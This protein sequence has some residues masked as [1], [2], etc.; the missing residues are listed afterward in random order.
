VKETVGINF[1]LNNMRL[2][3]KDKNVK[4]PSKFDIDAL[5]NSTATEGQVSRANH[6]EH[7]YLPKSNNKLNTI[8]HSI[9]HVDYN[10]D[11]TTSINNSFSTNLHAKSPSNKIFKEI[12]N[13]SNSLRGNQS[14]EKSTYTSKFDESGGKSSIKKDI[15]YYLTYLS[16]TNKRTSFLKTA[17]SD[18]NQRY[19]VDNYGTN[20]NNS[21]ENKLMNLLFSKKDKK[22][23]NQN[24][25]FES[26]SK[27]FSSNNTNSKH[28]LFH[29]KLNTIQGKFTL[30]KTY[31]K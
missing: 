21:K 11:R 2:N 15:D 24:H 5:F 14:G 18:N 4:K 23:G 28:S 9:N 1:E 8:N 27:E 17:N 7:F 20:N 26:F 12:N 31:L 10:R 3:N 29:Q 6:H 19:Q 13:Y 16:P 30:G 25:E 22:S